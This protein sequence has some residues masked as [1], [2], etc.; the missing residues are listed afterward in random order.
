MIT[1]LD[2]FGYGLPYKERYELIKEVGFD[3]VL[4]Y[5]SD[6]FGNLDYKH[7]AELARR[8]G[9]FVENIHI[10]FDNIN[11]LWLDNLSGNEI[12]DYLIQCVDDCL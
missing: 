7:N 8:E 6:K 9:L 12:T 5:W 1:I 3:G 11:D 4:L 10:S 2:W